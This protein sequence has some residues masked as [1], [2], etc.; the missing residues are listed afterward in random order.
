MAFACAVEPDAVRLPV[1]HA[2][3]AA[4]AVLPD[5]AA[6]AGVELLAELLFVPHAASVK[7][8]IATAAAAPRRRVRLTRSPFLRHPM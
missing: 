7:V 1:A 2:M 6:E 4:D 5:V 3:A 8:P